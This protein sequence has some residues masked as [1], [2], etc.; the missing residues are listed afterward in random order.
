MTSQPALPLLPLPLDTGLLFAEYHYPVAK[1]TARF[2]D[3]ILGKPKLNAYSPTDVHPYLGDIL[4]MGHKQHPCIYDRSCRLSVLACSHLLPLERARERER[5]AD[6]K[7][8]DIMHDTTAQ[9]SVTIPLQLNSALPS[10][11]PAS[12]LHA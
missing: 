1:R 11:P 10:L 6:I 12:A 9:F 2:L 3:D 7:A 8:Q 5:T 4:L